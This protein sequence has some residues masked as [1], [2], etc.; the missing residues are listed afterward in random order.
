[1]DDRKEKQEEKVLNFMLN[2]VVPLAPFESRNLRIVVAQ[3]D[4]RRF[5]TTELLT[6]DMYWAAGAIGSVS[7]SYSM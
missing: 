2:D 5:L 1:M 4:L 6:N 7:L 3:T